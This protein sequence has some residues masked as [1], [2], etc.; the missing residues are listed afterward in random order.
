MGVH[1]S[2]FLAVLS[3]APDILNIEMI[4]I[5]IESVARPG[6]SLD[7]PASQR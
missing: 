6:V 1:A 5:E 4:I 7:Q 3:R 2:E